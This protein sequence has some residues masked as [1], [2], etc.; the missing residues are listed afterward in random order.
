MASAVSKTCNDFISQKKPDFSPEKKEVSSDPRL[1]SFD[2]S[3]RKAG[4]E[5][6]R[7]DVA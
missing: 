6:R 5:G 4:R 7:N 1:F 3:E 2:E